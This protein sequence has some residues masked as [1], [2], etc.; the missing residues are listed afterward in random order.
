MIDPITVELSDGRLFRLTGLDVPD[1]DVYHSGPLAQTALKVLQDMLEDEYVNIYQTVKK[2]GGLQDRLGNHLA[3]LE[4]KDSGVWVQ[5]ALLSLGLA[6][7]L[8]MKSN[9]EM[10]A[11]MYAAEAQAR[12]AGAGLWAMERYAILT[13]DQALE[14]ENSLQIVEGKVES[15]AMTQN[16]I[17]LNFGKNWKNDFTVSIAPENRKAFFSGNLDPLQLN[18]RTIR[19]RGWVEDYNGPFIEIDHPERI[20]VLE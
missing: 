16:R 12:E 15:A 10:A 11:Q 9:V 4:L 18:G 8:T 19:V 6:R 2:D 17:Y 3:H 14:H 13:P 7:V 5:G 20:E 1:F